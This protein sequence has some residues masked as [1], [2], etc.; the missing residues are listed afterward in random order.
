MERILLSA[1]HEETVFAV[2]RDG[3]LDE[4]KIE[5]FDNVD[6]VGRIYNCLLYTSDAADE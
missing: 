5:Y 4:L 1:K 6:L 3:K 2:L